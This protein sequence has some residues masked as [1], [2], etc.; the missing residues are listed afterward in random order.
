[1]EKFKPSEL[2]V[3]EGPD[4]GRVEDPE[5]ALEMAKTEEKYGRKGKLFGLIKPSERKIKQ[6]EEAAEMVG[7]LHLDFKNIPRKFQFNREM[8]DEFERRMTNFRITKEWDNNIAV[9][10]DVDGHNIEADLCR[11]HNPKKNQKFGIISMS[12]DKENLTSSEIGKF[13]F[14]ELR[15]LEMTQ[16]I[17][18]EKDRGGVKAKINKI[19][20]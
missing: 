5:I 18:D 16:K 7:K 11:K 20:E 4:K 12:L 19:L 14:L 1:M 13:E 8:S 9:A 17:K 6:G 10:F 2:Y 3:K 15:L